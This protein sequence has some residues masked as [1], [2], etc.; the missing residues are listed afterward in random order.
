MQLIH[1]SL[2]NIIQS[3]NVPNSIAIHIE[4]NI[5]ITFFQV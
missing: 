2:T 3:N 4:Q 5:N 1:K